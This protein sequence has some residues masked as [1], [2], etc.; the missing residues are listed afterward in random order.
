MS[1]EWNGIL[2]IDKP[3]GLTSHDVVARVR[4]CFNMR[5]VG[6]CGTLDPMASGL[7]I[8]LLGGATKLSD[9]L[10]TQ[11]KT[12]QTTVQLGM[13]TDSY[14]RM[15]NIISKSEEPVSL[16]S[17]QAAI[18][19]LTGE[20]ELD[21][22][23]FSAKKVDGKK[24]YEY[25]RENKPIQI[26]RKKMH[27]KEVVLENFEDRQVTVTLSCS[28]GSFIRAWGHE[29]GQLL[30]V[31]GTLTQLRRLRSQPWGLENAIPLKKILD[32]KHEN[33]EVKL[34]DLGSAYIS[35]TDAL[36]HLKM[37][38]ADLREQKL[39][40]NGQ[41]PHSLSSRLVFDLKQA[42]KTG[43]PLGI[44]VVR[45]TDQSLL[46]ILTALP[47]KGLKIRRVFKA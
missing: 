41:I 14:D 9:Y 2:L 8:V 5:A 19:S 28:K 11:E 7:L 30:R 44:R 46:A 23:I 39:L 25:A 34:S 45:Q 40:S 18:K 12:Y 17:V 26:P 1:V 3:E 6:H 36:P 42:F 20:V 22:P 21:I 10:L 47:E 38:V 24:L 29:L 27:F 13:T 37:V 16:E 33:N 15:G 35:A 43:E 4:R 31:G 32:L